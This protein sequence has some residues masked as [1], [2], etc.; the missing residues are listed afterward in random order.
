[1]SNVKIM[2]FYSG[3]VLLGS[4]NFSSAEH[5]ENDLSASTSVQLHNR[6][7]RG[8]YQKLEL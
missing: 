3:L 1:M 5:R 6:A 4:L 2:M 8:K 7:K